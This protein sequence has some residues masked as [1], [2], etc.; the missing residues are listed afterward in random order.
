MVYCYVLYCILLR[1]ELKQLL[2][3]AQARILLQENERS[4]QIGTRRQTDLDAS[5][6]LISTPV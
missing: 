2:R 4:S 3:E 6:V 5:S 1:A